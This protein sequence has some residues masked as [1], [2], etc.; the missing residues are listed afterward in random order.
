MTVTELIQ[1]LQTMSPDAVV[2][3]EGYETGFESIKK[4]ELLKVELNDAQNWWD[5]KFEKSNNP[6]AIE[7]VFINAETKAERK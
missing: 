2:V 7:V 6:D 5:G 3:T 1:I 4:V